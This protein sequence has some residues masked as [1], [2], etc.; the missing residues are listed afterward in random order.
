MTRILFLYTVILFAASCF[1]ASR[2]LC[3]K[4][5]RNIDALERL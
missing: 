5:N 4:I 1:I 2:K 3:D